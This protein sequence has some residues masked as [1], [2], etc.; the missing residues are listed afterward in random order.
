VATA[1]AMSGSFTTA[2]VVA[3]SVT[4]VLMVGFGSRIPIIALTAH[5]MEGD[6]QRCLD[7]DMDGG[8]VTKPAASSRLRGNTRLAS[9]ADL[10]PQ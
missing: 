6:R 7:A 10:M 3:V 4:E 1:L 5:A 9:H 8:Y 2:T